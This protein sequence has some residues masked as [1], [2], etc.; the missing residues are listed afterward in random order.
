MMSSSSLEAVR[1]TTG[2]RRV[3]SSA[4][5]RRSTSSPSTRGSL[6][7]SR[8]TAGS[9]FGSRPLYSPVQNRYSSASAPSR[10]TAIW[11]FRLH[12]LNARAISF[13]SVG[14]S[15]T[16]STILLMV[17]LPRLGWEREIEGGAFADGAL[18]PD[19]A[20][21]AVD[22]PLRGGQPDSCPRELTDRMQTLE[23]GEQLAGMRHVETDA[24]VAHEERPADHG[25]GNPHFDA[26]EGRLAAEFP[27]VPKQVLQ[28]RA[29][30][31]RVDVRLKTVGDD[32]L[33]GTT[34][35]SA[36][37]LGPDAARQCAQVD[38][39]EIRLAARNPRQREKRVDQRP[40][41]HCVV[42]D[43]MQAVDSFGVETALV[44]LE[45]DL[46]EPVHSPEWS[47]EIVGHRVAER[48][49]LSVR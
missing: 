41:A 8:M 31:L 36:D 47:A 2:R 48:L 19:A 16:S 39:F 5:M 21:V 23:R 3:R 18:G 4:R 49:E 1:I 40:H 34:R 27:G 45:E 37:E 28:Q 32:E 15:S 11:L 25:G 35:L 42:V 14:L 24:V 33:H 29:N 6:R 12:F 26:R 10:T 22:D 9:S 44:F 30:E 17:F 38:P 43:L 46:R 13:S 20:A 7:S